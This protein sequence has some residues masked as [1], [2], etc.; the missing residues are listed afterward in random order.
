[1][2]NLNVLEIYFVTKT[3]GSRHSLVLELSNVLSIKFTLEHS[4][5]A[6]FNAFLTL[7]DNAIGS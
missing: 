1:M 2:I 3:T 4:V 6:V 5:G 7:C